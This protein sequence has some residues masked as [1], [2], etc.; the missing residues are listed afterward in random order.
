MPIT[1]E[2]AQCPLGD[3]TFKV[4]Y[5]HFT[6]SAVFVKKLW[7][8]GTHLFGICLYVTCVPFWLI[9]LFPVA[10]FAIQVQAVQ[11]RKQRLV[12]SERGF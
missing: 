12:I 3:L 1:H 7:D 6:C 11:E 2:I 9:M 10:L 4:R 8:I 5:S